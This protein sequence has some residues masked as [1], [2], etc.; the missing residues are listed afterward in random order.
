MG[1]VEPRVRGGNLGGHG[2]CKEMNRYV[3]LDAGQ[4]VEPSRP[5]AKLAMH[6]FEGVAQVLRLVRKVAC[7]RWVWGKVCGQ[8]CKMGVWSGTEACMT[9]VGH[10]IW[11]TR[12]PHI[13]R[14]SM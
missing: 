6:Q 9:P 13:S 7:S 4:T 12:A 8:A 5:L 1:A 3:C 11:G 14:F 10:V 2:C